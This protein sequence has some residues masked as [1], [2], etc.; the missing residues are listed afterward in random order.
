MPKVL[1]IVS[2]LVPSFHPLS[3]SV[4]SPPKSRNSF[5][6]MLLRTLGRSQ[7]SQVLCN[8]A[9]PDSLCKT[10]GVGHPRPFRETLGRRMPRRSPSR[11]TRH[12][13]APFVFITLQIPWRA[14]RLY[15]HSYKT[16]GVWGT[17]TFNFQL[18]RVNR[19]V[20]PSRPERSRG[21]STAFLPRAKSRGTPT[22]AAMRFQRKPEQGYPII[23][24]AHKQET[25]SRTSA[26]CSS[27]AL[28][29]PRPE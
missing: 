18:P 14:T 26:P 27:T 4:F 22:Q 29:S 9:N 7:K 17:A 1:L 6:L 21:V 25:T 24:S 3:Q 23:L 15:S 10:P 5:T 13:S 8:Q 16:P 12:I 19:S 20:S 11:G 2:P 28:Q